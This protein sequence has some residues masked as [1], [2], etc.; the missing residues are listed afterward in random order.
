MDAIRNLHRQINLPDAVPGKHTVSL[1]KRGL[2]MLGAVQVQILHQAPPPKQDL[3]GRQASTKGV[4][5][6]LFLPALPQKPRDGPPPLLRMSDHKDNLGHC[7]DKAGDPS[8]AAAK[9]ATH[10][11]PRGLVDQDHPRN[12]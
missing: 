12:D 1:S 7:S 10:N 5:K 8:V 2:E 6:Q 3:D 11:I 4:T 9:L